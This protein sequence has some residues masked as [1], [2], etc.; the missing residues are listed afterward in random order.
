MSTKIAT[1]YPSLSVLLWLIA[2]FILAVLPHFSRLPLWIITS[3]ALLLI[4]RYLMT[5]WQWKRPNIWIQFGLGLLLLLG[6][7]ASYG[8]WLGRDAGIALLIVLCALKLIE[9]TSQRDALLICFLSYFLV[10]THFLY[11]QSILTLLYTSL[12]VIVATT[13][14][15][16]IND[17]NRALSSYQRLR[18]AGILLGQAIPIMIVLFVLFPRIPGPFWNL[19]KDAYNA[20]T[21]LSDSLTL[22]NISELSLSDEV[23]F[24]VKFDDKIP[25]SEELYW[26]GPVLWWTNGRNWKMRSSSSSI[27]VNYIKL[28]AMGQVYDYRITLESH[29]KN[30]L[31]ALDLPTQIPSQAYINSDYQLLSRLPIRQRINYKIRSYTKYQAKAFTDRYNLGLQ[32]PKKLHPRTRALAK[33]WWQENPQPRA[34]IKRALEHFSQEPFVYTYTPPKLITDTVDEFLFETHQG[35]CEHYAVAFTVLMRAVGIPTR[36]VTG[37]LGGSMNP[38]GDYMIVRQ[39]NAHAWTEVWLNDQGWVRIDPTAVI[40]PERIDQ[41]VNISELGLDLE[42]DSTSIQIWEQMNYLLDAANNNWN[43]WVLSYD[44]VKQQQ[45]LK[46]M[47]LDINWQGM[48]ILLTV[49]IAILLLIYASWMFWFTQ[50]KNINKEQYL[51]LRFC[52]KLAKVGLQHKSAE[53]PLDYAKRVSR[54]RPDLANA[55]KQI[56]N[57]YIQ[58]RYCSQIENLAKFKQAIQQFHPR[59]RPKPLK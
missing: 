39:R 19:P 54:M 14:L 26:R 32:L 27:S 51:Y 47:G 57:F 41:S 30:W 36:I 37:Y 25:P 8:T 35:F 24:R 21:G 17:N 49:I 33:Q 20:V 23:A 28:N 5:R 31:F 22:G 12:I 15:I 58:I 9:M 13:T 2:T 7:M 40:A 56:I 29:D 10:I 52:K 6:L 45:L 43:Q 59:K 1:S 42:P 3:L 44:K 4:W 48:T 38:I 34:M 18:L 11:S 46:N 53:G 16:S 55:V 50:Y